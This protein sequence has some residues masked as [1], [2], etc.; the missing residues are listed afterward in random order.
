MLW[1]TIELLQSVCRKK[2]E[3]DNF[4]DTDSVQSEG[5]AMNQH[6]HSVL[7]P[8]G[9]K[10]PCGMFDPFSLT[11]VLS[12]SLP[13]AT[14]RSI[15]ACLFLIPCLYLF[16]EDVAKRNSRFFTNK[17]SSVHRK[18]VESWGDYNNQRLINGT[19]SENQ[20]RFSDF[21]ITAS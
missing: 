9:M 3:L 14:M 20:L 5:I 6:Y 2:I 12:S 19:T 1:N 21:Q 16:C 13:L 18:F 4:Y 10:Y 8:K 17:L 11:G 15:V 7:F